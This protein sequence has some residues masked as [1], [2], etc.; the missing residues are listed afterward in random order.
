MTPLFTSPYAPDFIQH[1]WDDADVLLVGMQTFP[2]PV[3]GT[4]PLYVISNDTTI[5]DDACNPLPD[6]TPDLSAF[7]VL[8][9]R[10]TCTFVSIWRCVGC[11]ILRRIIRSPSWRISPHLAP[12]LRSYMS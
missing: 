11:G 9:R 7:V 10:G 3:N 6:S 2:L 5:V 4:L 12:P 8:V 1:G